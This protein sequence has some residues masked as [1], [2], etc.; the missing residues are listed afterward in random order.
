MK[1]VLELTE[2]QLKVLAETVDIH[3]RELTSELVHTTER[4]YREGLKRKL[5]TLEQVE[6]RLS[7]ALGGGVIAT[8]P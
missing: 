5:E 1:I 6:V 4:E 3:R 7:A 2:P 8:A